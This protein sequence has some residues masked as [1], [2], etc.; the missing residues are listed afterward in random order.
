MLA[1]PSSEYNPFLRLLSQGT[2]I[3]T[4]LQFIFLDSG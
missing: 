1:N 3:D 2:S 4:I